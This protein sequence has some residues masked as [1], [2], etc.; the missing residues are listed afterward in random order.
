LKFFADKESR[1]HN[2][3]RF[4]N[5]APKAV[6]YSQHEYGEAFS[7][8]AVPKSGKRPIAYSARGSHANYAKAGKHDLHEGSKFSFQFLP[9]IS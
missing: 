6:W 5:G 1:E 8:A 9:A 4:Q 7:Y 3:V 2:M